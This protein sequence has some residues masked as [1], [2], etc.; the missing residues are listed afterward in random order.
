MTAPLGH[1]PGTEALVHLDQA[2]AGRPV[3]Q[4]KGER[5]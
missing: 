1:E 2:T 5:P 3:V 4:S